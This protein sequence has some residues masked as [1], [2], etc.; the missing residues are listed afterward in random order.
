MR[1]CR[2]RGRHAVITRVSGPRSSFN[3]RRLS[4]AMIRN[5]TTI[6]KGR[7][8]LS[9]LWRTV[10]VGILCAGSL[11]ADGFDHPTKRFFPDARDDIKFLFTDRHNLWSLAVGGA[12]ALSAT[13]DD[14]LRKR[15]RDPGRGD[16]WDL[17]NALETSGTVSGDPRSTEKVAI[18][19]K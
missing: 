4:H 15:F 13:R 12:T 10:A 11:A 9:R 6:S 5:E 7:T 1:Q 14:P 17:K 16:Q 8:R 2:N 19:G 3:P 18:R